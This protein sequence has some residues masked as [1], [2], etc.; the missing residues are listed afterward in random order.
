[1][2][3]KGRLAEGVSPVRSRSLPRTHPATH[4]PQKGSNV[5]SPPP[6]KGQGLTRRAPP[7]P[8]GFRVF[9]PF[10]DDPLCPPLLRRPVGGRDVQREPLSALLHW[11][12]FPPKVWGL[13]DHAL[14][15]A[16]QHHVGPV[17]ALIPLRRRLGLVYTLTSATCEGRGR[18]EIN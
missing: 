3:H 11:A 12:L 2:R 16:F 9:P 1:M 4:R 17:C 13:E 8:R 10:R 5:E 18:D 7:I 14:L 15:A 6:T